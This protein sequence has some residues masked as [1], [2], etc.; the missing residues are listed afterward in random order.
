MLLWIATE[1][2]TAV[3]AV[4]YVYVNVLYSLLQYAVNM[5]ERGGNDAL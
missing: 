4:E 2:W 1:L 5:R 3:Y